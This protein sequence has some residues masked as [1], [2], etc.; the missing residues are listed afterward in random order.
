MTEILVAG[1]EVIEKPALEVIAMLNDSCDYP[2]DVHKDIAQWREHF[3][4]YLYALELRPS[5]VD[6][7]KAIGIQK[8]GLIGHHTNWK[9]NRTRLRPVPIERYALE[10]G[11]HR[12]AAALK[13]GIP[14]PAIIETDQTGSLRR[15][16]QDYNLPGGR[17]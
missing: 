14:Y 9:F 4:K 16:T 8:P 15:H 3:T 17:A 7:V 1:P 11:H 12:L 6:S 10:N 13:L 5:F 2:S